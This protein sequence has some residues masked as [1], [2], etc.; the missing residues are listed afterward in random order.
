M[1]AE[2][3]RSVQVLLVE[4]DEDHAFL[5]RESFEQARLQIP[6]NHVFDGVQC[7][8]FLR[9]EPPYEAAPVIDLILLDLNMPRLSG[10]EVLKILKSDPKLMHIPVVILTTST[11]PED[12]ARVYNLHGNSFIS[13]PVDFGNFVDAVNKL[14]NYWFS[15]VKL[16]ADRGP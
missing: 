12:I 8:A 15:L 14:T 4:D 9:R 3:S 7:L 1:A 16:P 13:K 5:M 2:V 11:N 10:F 6:L